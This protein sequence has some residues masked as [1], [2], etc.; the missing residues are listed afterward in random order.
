MKGGK[1]KKSKDK[2]P[3]YADIESLVDDDDDDDM[4]EMN[5]WV[6]IEYNDDDEMV[7]DYHIKEGPKSCDTCKMVV[8]DGDSCD[9]LGDAHYDTEEN[10]W[11]YDDTPYITNKRR[12]AAGHFKTDNGYSYK[13]NECMFVVLYDEDDDDRRVLSSSN[14]TRVLKGKKSKGPKK[15]ACGQLRPDD[16]DEDYCD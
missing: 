3:L 9:D 7:I 13:D 11:S 5:G 15:L 4:S 8:M 10:P 2:A 16:E 12:R 14:G 6:S 1:S